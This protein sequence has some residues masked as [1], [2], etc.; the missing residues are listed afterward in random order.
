MN[1]PPDSFSAFYFAA[2]HQCLR[3]VAAHVG[4]IDS[5]EELVAEAFT[6]ALTRWHTVSTHPAPAAWVMITALN[7]QRDRWRRSR[8]GRRHVGA[9]RVAA[10][11]EHE[12]DGMQLSQHVLAA[13]HALPTRQREV[14]IHRI[15]LDLDTKTTASLLGIDPGTVTTHLRRALAAL[16]ASLQ[17][18]LQ[19]LS[20][21]TEPIAFTERGTHVEPAR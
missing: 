11:R 13:I 1:D 17:T 7:L 4:N 21:P 9:Q 12:D 19:T 8:L 16:R 14:V 15:I 18:S 3:A 10:V 2:R 6:R 5:A 20:A